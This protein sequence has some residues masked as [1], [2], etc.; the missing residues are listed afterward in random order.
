MRLVSEV[1]V[2][3]L[4]KL[5]IKNEIDSPSQSFLPNL[6][7]TSF[8]IN[9]WVCIARKSTFESRVTSFL[10][11]LLRINEVWLI[12]RVCCGCILAVLAFCE[13]NFEIIISADRIRQAKTNRVFSLQV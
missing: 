11:P 2:P 13:C 4:R 5:G 10:V 8:S 3:T 1:S 6:C 7:K 9:S 12:C